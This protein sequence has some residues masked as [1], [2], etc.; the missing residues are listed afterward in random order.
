MTLAWH[1]FS[2]SSY[3]QLKGPSEPE[4]ESLFLTALDGYFSLQW[5]TQMFFESIY[6]FGTGNYHYSF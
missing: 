5:F 1:I 3:L 4:A 2:A 6:V